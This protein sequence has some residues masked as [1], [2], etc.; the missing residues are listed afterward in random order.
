MAIELGTIAAVIQFIDIG[1]RLSTRLNSFCTDFRDAPQQIERV[2]SDLKQQLAI[3]QDIKS[4]TQVVSSEI[5]SLAPFEHPHQ[6]YMSLASNL[7]S[8]IEGL[9]NTSSDG[10]LKKSWTSLRFVRQK[11]EIIETCE[12]LYRKESSMTMWLQSTN[13]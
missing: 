5:R 10:I 6:E 2:N 7:Q 1:C 11:R 12:R 3:A 8:L 9:E 4:T 13:M